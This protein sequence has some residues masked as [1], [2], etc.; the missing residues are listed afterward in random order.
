MFL[1]SGTCEVKSLLWYLSLKASRVQAAGDVY[2]CTL[3]LAS[4]HGARLRLSILLSPSKRNLQSVGEADAFERRDD[5]DK[6][7]VTYLQ[8]NVGCLA[9]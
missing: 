4:K 7:G 3:G 5:R 6:R 9:G 2:L 1:S 8:A